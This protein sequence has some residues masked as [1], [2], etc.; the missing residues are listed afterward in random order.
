MNF[1]IGPPARAARYGP[2]AWYP[3]S[4]KFAVFNGGPVGIE[5]GITARWRIRQERARA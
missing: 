2:G 3:P 4:G 1:F 5:S